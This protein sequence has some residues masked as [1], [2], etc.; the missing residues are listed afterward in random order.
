SL[1]TLTAS[2]GRGGDIR[3]STPLLTLRDG[4][5][6]S[7]A[8]L[9]AA[10]AGNITLNADRIEVQGIGTN[11]GLSSR[12]EASAGTLLNFDN[13]NATGNGGSLNVNA[14]ELIVKD[15]A[16][17]NVRAL[18][19]GSAGNINVVAD[20]IALDNQSSIDGRTTSGLG[21]N[22]NMQSLA[23]QLRRN[24]RIATDAGESTGGNIAIDTNTLVALENSDITA[25]AQRGAGGR[26]S[27]NA[28]GIFG[29]QFRDGLTPQSD[30]TATSELGPQFSGVV[31]INTPDVDPSAG[32]VEL[33]TNF[34]EVSDRIATGCQA[35]RTDR[36]AVVGRSG[37]PVTPYDSL[38]GWYDTTGVSSVR[39]QQQQN[40]R[41]L[42]SQSSNSQSSIVEV[43][44][45][46]INQK[47]EVELVANA[48]NSSAGSAWSRLTGCGQ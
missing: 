32:L 13:P 47:G 12:I 26:V 21:A 27:I 16:I 38:N 15:G 17:F 35:S 19:T 39:T 6:I 42:R 4:A 23:L 44:R 34:A 22:I 45:W 46:E 33:S 20:S 3:L 11:R 1:T 24:S 30:I 28:Q 48:S 43:T 36:F 5:L 31:E 25:N 37:L 18:G 8:S 40:R 14:R 10:D 29:T 9:G 41:N 7:A 2:S